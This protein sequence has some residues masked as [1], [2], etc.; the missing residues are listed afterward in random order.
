MHERK[1]KA[2]KNIDCTVN[3]ADEHRVPKPV[4]LLVKSV[5]YSNETVQDG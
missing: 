1:K 4:T 2:N 5:F 3:K